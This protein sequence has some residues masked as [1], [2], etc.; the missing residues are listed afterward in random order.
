MREADVEAVALGGGVLAGYVEQ[1]GGGA[2]GDVG[3]AGVV[4]GGEGD[5]GVEIVAE[6]AVPDV[7]LA[8]EAG[9]GGEVA[10]EDVGVC[11]FD[12]RGGHVFGSTETSCVAEMC[13]RAV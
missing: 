6:L 12:G 13:F 1:P 11:V 7:V 9:G 2:G 4:G 8:V 3:D 5:G 10:I